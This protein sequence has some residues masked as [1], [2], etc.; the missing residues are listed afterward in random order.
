MALSKGRSPTP[1]LL[2][3]KDCK[4]IGRLVVEKGSEEAVDFVFD[5]LASAVPGLG[6]RFGR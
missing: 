2:Q 3:N 4:K 6:W 5:G 1:V